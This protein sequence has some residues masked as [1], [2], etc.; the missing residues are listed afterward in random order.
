MEKER[1]KNNYFS[2]DTYKIPY[3]KSKCIKIIQYISIGSCICM[4]AYNAYTDY[5]VRRIPCRSLFFFL[6]AFSF[7][8]WDSIKRYWP[9]FVRPKRWSTD[10]KIISKIEAYCNRYYHIHPMLRMYNN[11]NTPCMNIPSDQVQII[12]SQ[13]KNIYVQNDLYEYHQTPLIFVPF[14][15]AYSSYTKNKNNNRDMWQLEERNKITAQEFVQHILP[16]SAD[17]RE[18]IVDNDSECQKVVK[19]FWRLNEYLQTSRAMLNQEGL[20]FY[21]D[22]FTRDHY[23]LICDCC[24]SFFSKNNHR[25]PLDDMDTFAAWWHYIMKVPVTVYSSEYIEGGD[26]LYFKQTGNARKNNKNVMI[27]KPKQFDTLTNKQQRYIKAAKT[28]TQEEES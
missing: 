5:T 26:P 28:Y 14:Y 7:F 15:R 11:S 22:T 20:A 19:Q 18:R 16:L 3:Q 17:T 10:V 1:L 25:E 4:G 12:N 21:R 13:I 6:S 23:K 24:S 9:Y 2:T 27:Y 8:S